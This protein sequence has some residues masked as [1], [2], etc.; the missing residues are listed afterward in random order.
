MGTRQSRPPE[1]I[2]RFVYPWKMVVAK[3]PNLSGNGLNHESYDLIGSGFFCGLKEFWRK[4]TVQCF[5][6][7]TT[8]LTFLKRPRSACSQA[9]LNQPTNGNIATLFWK[10]YSKII[11]RVVWTQQNVTSVSSSKRGIASFT[12]KVTV[13]CLNCHH[14]PAPCTKLLLLSFGQLQFTRYSMWFHDWLI[15]FKPGT[16]GALPIVCSQPQPLT[17]VRFSGGR[18]C[19]VVMISI[20]PHH[21]FVNFT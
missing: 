14:A 9:G 2:T 13:A 18:L 1:I 8:E 4:L 20:S 11:Y 6:F 10:M 21:H 12:N 17:K 3:I 16:N 7:K 5:F 19:L 15:F